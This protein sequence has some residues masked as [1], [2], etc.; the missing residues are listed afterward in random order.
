[1]TRPSGRQPD[2]LRAVRFTRRFT[3]HAEGS[4]LVEFGDTH[5]LCTA[6]VEDSVPPFLRGKGQG[7]VTAEYGM[8][9]RATHTRIARARQQ[10]QA[11]RTHSGDSAAHRPLA[12]RGHRSEG[13]GRAHRHHRLR[14]AAGRWRHPHSLHHRRLCRAGRRLRTL[15][16]PQ[17]DFRQSASWTDRRDLRR[18]LQRRARARSRLC[19]RFSGRDGHER[20]HEQRRRFRRDSGH[21]GRSCV[22]PA[23][24]RRDAE[25]CGDRAR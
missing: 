4:V 18:H 9:P 16:A 21:R 14:R 22:P 23:R 19:G 13:T 12:A 17:A 1:M 2:Q 25:S 24:A 6:S 8:L 7:W 5:V 20:R 10:G 3:K 11:E 15:I